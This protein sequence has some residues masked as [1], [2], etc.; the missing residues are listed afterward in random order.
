M[1]IIIALPSYILLILLLSSCATTADIHRTKCKLLK[2]K[3]VFNAATSNARNAEID[4]AEESLQTH[5]YDTD[6]CQG[7]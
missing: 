6:N 1:K 3:I 2:S 4:R 5:N 7:M